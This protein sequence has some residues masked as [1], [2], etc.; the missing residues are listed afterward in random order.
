MRM[1][2]AEQIRAALPWPDLIDALGAAFVK[3]CE[4]P[5][6]HVHSVAVP[7]EADATLLLMSA[8]S[9]GAGMGVKLVSVT[10]GNAAR[11]LPAVN[12]IYVLFDGRTGVPMAVL[13]GEELTARRTA[14]ASALA[15]QYLARPDASRLLV[16]GAG[17][18][19]AELPHAHGAVRALDDVAIWARDA[20]KAQLLAARLAEQ[21]LP[22][23]AVTDLAAAAR[24]ADI[25]STAT[26]SVEPILRGE[27]LKPGA[28]LDLVGAFRKDMRETDDAAIARATL[29]ADTRA[30]VL[31]EGGD[32]VQAVRSGAIGPDPLAADLAD[33]CAGRHAGRSH[34]GEITL[35]KSVGA[36]IEDLAAAELVLERAGKVG[37]H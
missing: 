3:G 22:A 9:P 33:L 25:L 35:F 19:A 11:A 16:V 12:A 8:W 27:W 6:R 34:E 26:L 29:F 7:G 17:R 14:A 5:L 1:I 31:A 18:I 37:A 36:A 20:H 32:I 4:S 28:H 15:A 24:E 2:T 21:G 10:P 23:R 13:D 30:G